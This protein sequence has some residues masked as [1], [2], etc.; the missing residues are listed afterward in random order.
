LTFEIISGEAGPYCYNRS[1][2]H[3]NKYVPAYQRTHLLSSIHF[4]TNA[5]CDTIYVTHIQIATCFGTQVQPSGS[6]CNKG[7]GANLIIYVLFIV[8]S[9]M[10]T[11]VIKIQKMYKIHKI[12][13][14]SN[15]QCFDNILSLSRVSSY[16]LWV[17]VF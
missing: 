6:C 11:P 14:V 2:T 17:S 16:Q 15:L 13:I 7:V 10:D 4:P 9:L 3:Q 8:I 5:L 1:L 12:D